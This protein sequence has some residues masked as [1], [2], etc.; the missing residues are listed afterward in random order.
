MA[1]IK[2]SKLSPVRVPV[3]LPNGGGMSTAIRH[4]NLVPAERNLPGSPSA[5]PRPVVEPVT[6]EVPYTM[7]DWLV[8]KLRANPEA[9]ADLRA[10][11]ASMDPADIAELRAEEA[12]QQARYDDDM[13]SGEVWAGYDG[14]PVGGFGPDALQIR[15]A[16]QEV[17]EYLDDWAPDYSDDEM[18]A[19]A[20]NYSQK[21]EDA[22]EADGE[23]NA[24]G[25]LILPHEWLHD[26]DRWEG[27]RELMQA[28]VKE[29]NDVHFDFMG[30]RLPGI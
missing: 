9:V 24:D 4:K 18:A 17:R 29:F 7:P 6:A 26:S 1:K 21:T 30:Y 28:A 8:E 13:A 23:R 11:Y 15:D 12:A 19:I 16:T 27:Q 14:M 5:G 10:G 22:A 20:K 3:R 2:S 25:D